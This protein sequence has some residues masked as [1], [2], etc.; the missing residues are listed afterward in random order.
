MPQKIN[1][2][3]RHRPLPP[4]HFIGIRLRRIL[5]PQIFAKPHDIRRKFR[6]LD[7]NDHQLLL[8]VGLLNLCA[9]IHPKNRQT[10]S[11]SFL[12]ILGRAKGQGLDLLADQRGKKKPGDPIV[13]EQIFERYIVNRI[14]NPQ[15]MGALHPPTLPTPPHRSSAHP[16]RSQDPFTLP[17]I[18]QS[19][20]QN[21]PDASP[22]Q[23]Q[24]NPPPHIFQ[25]LTQKNFSPPL[26]SPILSQK[27]AS[28]LRKEPPHP[29]KYLVI[30]TIATAILGLGACAK[31]TV[32][33]P[34]PASTGLTK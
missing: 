31:K 23:P 24:T 26:L 29:M 27:S 9:K 3:N 10:P 18:H 12:K 30:L 32:P 15:G 11:T 25:S 34:A 13:V 8:A 21:R 4:F 17:P 1:A 33:A 2:E 5:M 22:L 16:H 20:P 19:P 7:F 6:L 28:R 14:R